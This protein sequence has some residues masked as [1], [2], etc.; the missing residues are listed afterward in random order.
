MVDTLKDEV[1]E[2]VERGRKKWRGGAAQPQ[3][4]QRNGGR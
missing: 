3:S 1:G 4:P 2:G